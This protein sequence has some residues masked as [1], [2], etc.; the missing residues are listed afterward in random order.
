MAKNTKQTA[1]NNEFL[2][3]I[4]AEFNHKVF[5]GASRIMNTEGEEAVCV[6]LA[7]YSRRY[8]RMFCI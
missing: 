5:A 6:Y 7:K 3:T 4:K 2:K 8:S 1:G